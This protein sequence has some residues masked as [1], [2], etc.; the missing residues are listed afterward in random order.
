MSDIWEGNEGPRDSGVLG[1]DARIEALLDEIQERAVHEKSL[2]AERDALRAALERYG[3]HKNDATDFCQSYIESTRP[4][5][6]GFDET[7]RGT[8]R[9]A[10]Q[11]SVARGVGAGACPEC[12]GEGGDCPECDGTGVARYPSWSKRPTP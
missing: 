11:P 12:A 2:T 1:G 4:C 9:A 8:E 6:C 5:T 7:L 10:D 3:T